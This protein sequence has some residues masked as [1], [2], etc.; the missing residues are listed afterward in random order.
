MIG[1]P[2]AKA[3]G[4]WKPRERALSL[5]QTE[6]VSVVAWLGG[7]SV[8]ALAVACEVSRSHMSSMLSGDVRMGGNHLGSLCVLLGLDRSRVEQLQ[9]SEPK[10]R[11]RTPNGAS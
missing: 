3:P 11:R 4:A 1:G 9:V 10:N 6:A 7:H 8:E 2:R 5:S